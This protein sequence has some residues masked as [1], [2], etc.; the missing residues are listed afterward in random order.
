MW[1][2]EVMTSEME[3]HFLSCG[4]FWPENG[5]LDLLMTGAFSVI[6]LEG[7]VV[8]KI[9]LISVLPLLLCLLSSFR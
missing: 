5:I 4:S 7:R 3:K 9:A 2:V 6:L 1:K 8:R